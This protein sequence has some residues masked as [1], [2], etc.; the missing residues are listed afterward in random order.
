MGPNAVLMAP[1][2][3]RRRP[4]PVL[5]WRRRSRLASRLDGTD[6]GP[7]GGGVLFI[8]HKDEG[9]RD[10]LETHL[11]MLKRQGFIETWHDRRITAGE[12]LEAAISGNLE[13]ADVVLLLVS[14]DFLASDYCYDKERQ[15][16]AWRA[17]W[18]RR[19]NRKSIAEFRVWPKLPNRR[20]HRQ[21]DRQAFDGWDRS[22]R[23]GAS[24][25]CGQRAE[26]SQR[27]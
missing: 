25:G 19:R 15:H 2:F 11:S 23:S 16:A 8:S 12:P 26:K 9:L 3:E 1:T 5:E 27:Q 22:H 4:F 6:R 20:S 24:P 10:Q 21:R 14:P 13:R 7:N 17:M 18:S